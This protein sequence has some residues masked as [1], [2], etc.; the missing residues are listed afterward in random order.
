MV[1]VVIITIVHAPSLIAGSNS[2]EA[3]A[4]WQDPLASPCTMIIAEK[5]AAANGFNH[6]LAW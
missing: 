1:A 3:C 5:F 4:R 2:F 6:Y